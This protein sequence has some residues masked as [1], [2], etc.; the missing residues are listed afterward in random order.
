M[1]YKPLSK[2]ATVTKIYFSSNSQ[3]FFVLKW[4]LLN[5]ITR[6]MINFSIKYMPSFSLK[7]IVLLILCRIC[8]LRCF[9]KRNLLKQCAKLN[10]T[11]MSWVL[12]NRTSID[13]LS[14]PKAMHQIEPNLCLGHSI[15]KTK[16]DV[17]GPHDTY[18]AC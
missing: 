7:F 11:F 9:Q 8:I 16:K 3:N 5:L 12:G 15:S 18:L 10:H 14:S 1:S 17:C 13:Y 2:M 4:K 6:Y